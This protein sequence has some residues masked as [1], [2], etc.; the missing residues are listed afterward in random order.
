MG[1]ALERQEE[2]I[3]LPGKEC[4]L[5][6]LSMEVGGALDSYSSFDCVSSGCN[7]F[8]LAV[9][10]ASSLK[11]ATVRDVTINYLDRIQISL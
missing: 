1:M 6:G 11:T 5:R 2:E 3:Y 10:S 7:S 9:F 4:S 8:F